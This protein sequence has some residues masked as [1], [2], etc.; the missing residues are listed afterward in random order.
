MIYNI[1]ISYLDNNSTTP[2]DPR[3]IETMLPFLKDNFANPS[4]NHHIGQSINK[5]VE[6]ARKTNS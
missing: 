4:S 1:N 2:I 6:E 3:V 5:E